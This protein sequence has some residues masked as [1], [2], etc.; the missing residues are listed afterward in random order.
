MWAKESP[1]YVDVSQS[2][3]T[4]PLPLRTLSRGGG[5][6]AP[7]I[8]F[9]ATFRNGGHNR[10]RAASVVAPLSKFSHLNVGWSLYVSFCTHG[11]HRVSFEALWVPFGRRMPIFKGRKR[12]TFYF[13]PW[14][15]IF[16]PVWG[17]WRL[18]WVARR[19]RVCP[20]ARR[21]WG[22]CASLASHV[23]RAVWALASPLGS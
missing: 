22:R 2:R 13:L 14:L 18:S 21:L 10:C 15:S 23:A 3:V 5:D 7:L 17:F 11:R 20:V 4:I 16:S 6:W 12:W 8:A 1:Q 9:Q 19:C